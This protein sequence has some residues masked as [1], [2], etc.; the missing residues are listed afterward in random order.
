[1]NFTVIRFPIQANFFTNCH[2]AAQR[3]TSIVLLKDCMTILFVSPK[4]SMNGHKGGTISPTLVR[5]QWHG[6][7]T[8]GRLLQLPV[9]CIEDTSLP[10]KPTTWDSATQTRNVECSRVKSGLYLCSQ[11]GCRFSTF[12]LLL[13]GCLQASWCLPCKLQPTRATFNRP[14]QSHWGFW[15]RT[16]FVTNFT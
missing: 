3:L 6:S 2:L 10:A 1:M 5:S 8:F 13:S 15:W 16:I 9:V 4:R 14:K 11:H 7:R 12:I